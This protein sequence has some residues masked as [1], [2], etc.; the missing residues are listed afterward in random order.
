MARHVLKAE[1]L[2]RE[3][4]APFGEV[5]DPEGAR[6]FPI[7]QGAMERFDALASVAV[8]ANGRAGVSMVECKRAGSVPVPVPLLERH[9]LGSQA[10]VPVG[11][12]VMCVVVAPPGDT[13]AVDRLRAFIGNG[14]QG[15]N[16]RPGTWHMPLVA[17]EEGQRFIVVDRGGPGN[18]CEEWRFDPSVEVWVDAKAIRALGAGV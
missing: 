9:P 3:T 12:A 16:Y 14:L 4:F 17:F 11:R 6:H 1:P 15:V 13:V 7:N 5:I 18:N 8:D 2:A 10:F